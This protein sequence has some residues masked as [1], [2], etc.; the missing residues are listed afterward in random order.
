MSDTRE[1]LD[2]FWFIPT[3]GD[4]PY[5]GTQDRHRPAEFR[6]LREIATAVDRLGYKGALL[7]TGRGC[8]DAW[9][10][11]TALATATERL[12]F[13]VALRPRISASRR[14]SP[15]ATRIWRRHTTSPSC[16]SRPSASAPSR[17]ARMSRIPVS[18]APVPDGRS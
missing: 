1:P 12:R 13:L 8:E 6:Y 18:S 16:C 9:I 3:R 11:A 10:T 7:P 14:S 5:L 4:G 2:L 15:P 17:P